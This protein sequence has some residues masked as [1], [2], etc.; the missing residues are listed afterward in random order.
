MHKLL[1]DERD[2]KYRQYDLISN[3]ITLSRERSRAMCQRVN[4]GNFG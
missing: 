2:K 1:E 3:V 4:S